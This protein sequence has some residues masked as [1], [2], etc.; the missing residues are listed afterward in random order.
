MKID[1]SNYIPA[2]LAAHA[3][4]EKQ[5]RKPLGIICNSGQYSP[6][7]GHWQLF[8]SSVSAV[9]SLRRGEIMPYYQGQPVSWTLIEYDLNKE[10]EI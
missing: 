10:A 3:A 5:A 2:I 6:Q 9:V 7:A 4:E 8:G 1:G